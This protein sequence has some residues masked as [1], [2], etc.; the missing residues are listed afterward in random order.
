MKTVRQLQPPRASRL[1]AK[2]SGVK[3]SNDARIMGAIAFTGELDPDLSGAA[4]ALRKAGFEL[5]MMPERFRSYLAHPDDY[6]MEASIAGTQDDKSIR[7][8]MNQINAIVDRFKGYCW[9]C[10][11]ILSD[12]V[13]FEDLFVSREV[14][15]RDH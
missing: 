15:P 14:K 10:G 13:P 11:P 6:F 1:P 12:H 2:L 8:I 7:A 4:V 9:E 5:T 3:K